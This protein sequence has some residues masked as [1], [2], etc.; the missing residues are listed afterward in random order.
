MPEAHRGAVHDQHAT[1]QALVHRRQRPPGHHG[2]EVNLSV[3]AEDGRHAG[4]L[5]RGR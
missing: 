5:L 3:P 4:D 1:V 2:E